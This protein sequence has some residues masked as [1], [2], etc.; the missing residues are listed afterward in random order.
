MTS[1]APSDLAR[2]RRLLGSATLGDLFARDPGRFSR[3]SFEWDDWLLDLS[4]ERLGPE[5]LPLLVAHATECGLPGWM[6]ALLAGE[7]VNQSERRPALYTALRQADDTPLVV[8]GRNIIPDVRVAQ[9]KMRMLAAQIRGGLRVGATGRSI[10]AVVNLGIGGSDLGAYLVC[11]ALAQPPRARGSTG[12]Q[13]QGVDVSFVSNVDPEHLTRALA[14]LDPASTLFLVTSKSFLTQETLANAASARD[15][16]VAAL[17]KGVNVNSHFMAT[18]ANQ[19]AARSF[20]IVAAD[21]LPMWDWVGGRFSLWSAAGLPIA[22]KLG[23]ERFEKLLV[24]AASIDAHFRDAPLERNLP[25]LLGLVGWWNATHLKHV[26]RVVVPYSQALSRLPAYLQQLVLESHGKCVGRDGGALT[27]SHS[28]AIWGEVGSNSQHSFFQWLH[29][30][31]REAPVEFI[32]PVAA[33]HP[34]GDQ[35][36]LLVGNALASARA[37]MTGRRPDDI[38]NELA[39]QGLSDAE[40]DAAV[41]ARVCPGNRASTML[42]MPELS[43]YRLGQLLAMYEHRTFVEAM[44][45][46]INPFDEF[47]V[48]YGRTLAGPIVAA[49]ARGAE[50]P[51]DTDGSTRGLVAHVRSLS[52][53]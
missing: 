36:T 34:V 27:E 33:T 9:G 26:E 45:Y 15:W 21:I 46:G 12:L 40:L 47:G 50:L 3:L 51:P 13:T 39:V 25:V 10:R 24:G 37:L 41:A 4:K 31:P 19:A 42:L 7:K 14:P 32:V 43:P 23:W 5:T 17:G 53:K 6:A 28:P 16:L 48:E 52:A 44:L 38:R 2:E 22:L 1:A 49:L 29:Q 35:Q 30:G 8:D 18:T 20:G 11:S